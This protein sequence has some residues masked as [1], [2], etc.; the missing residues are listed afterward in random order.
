MSWIIAMNIQVNCRCFFLWTKTNLVYFSHID[1]I[2]KIT[3][4]YKVSNA[5]TSNMISSRSEVVIACYNIPH[6]N[7][8]LILDNLLPICSGSK[9]LPLVWN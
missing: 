3:T 1:T 2:Q 8:Q 4:V 7:V 9:A 6:K 5:Q